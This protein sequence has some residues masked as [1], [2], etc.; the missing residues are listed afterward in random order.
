MASGQM[1]GASLS[2]V[3]S[4]GKLPFTVA[5]EHESHSRKLLWIA[6]ASPSISSADSLVGG[7]RLC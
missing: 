3:L 2:L 1:N 4:T 5:V 6:F 7:P